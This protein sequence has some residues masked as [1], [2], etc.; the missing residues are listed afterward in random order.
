MLF[1]QQRMGADDDVDRAFGQRVLGLA[2]RPSASTKRDSWRDPQRQ[3]GKAFGRRCGNA[4]APA[5]WSAPPPP[6]AC[7]PWR[8]QRRRAARLRSCRSRHRRRPADPSAGPPARSSITSA[9]ARCLVFGLGIGEAGG[10]FVVEPARAART[11][12]QV[13]SWRGRRRCG[14]ARAAI[15]RS[16]FF[17]RALRVCQPAPPSRSSC[18]AARPSRSASAARCSRPAGTACRR[19]HSSSRQSC[20]A[21]AT[22]I[23]F[24]P[25]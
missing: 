11:R 25:R 3:A 7:P 13:C 19:H 10:E 20:G 9:M 16:R 6:P 2:W 15:S 12:R 5:A 14:S 24:S 1:G 8:R 18:A 21:P 17:T 4:G 23:V 22:S